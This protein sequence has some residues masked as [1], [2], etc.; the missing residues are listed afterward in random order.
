MTW[1]QPSLGAL[2]VRLADGCV[3]RQ[4]RWDLDWKELTGAHD[5]FY[6]SKIRILEWDVSGCM[7][8]L[9]HQATISTQLFLKGSLLTMWGVWIHSIRW[10]HHSDLLDCGEAAAEILAQ[11]CVWVIKSLVGLC[12][13]STNEKQN[14]RSQGWELCATF[15]AFDFEKTLLKLLSLWLGKWWVAYCINTQINLPSNRHPSDGIYVLSQ[16]FYCRPYLL[17]GSKKVKLACDSRPFISFCWLS[18]EINALKCWTRASE[19]AKKFL[20]EKVNSPFLLIAFSKATWKQRI[21]GACVYNKTAWSFSLLF[22]QLEDA[23]SLG[24]TKNFTAEMVRLYKGLNG[25]FWEN[26]K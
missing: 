3:E 6:L 12:L 24:Q 7:V 14:H 13:K 17:V 23:K 11:P 21:V 19:Q 15:S 9:H 18:A 25:V 5:S 1:V 10:I 2:L 20:Q 22:L 16:H 4:P 26:K 8:L